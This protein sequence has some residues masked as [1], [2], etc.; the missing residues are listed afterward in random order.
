[1][2]QEIPSIMLIFYFVVPPIGAA[3]NAAVAYVTLRSKALRSPCN[4]LIALLSLADAVQLANITICM[5]F[6]SIAQNNRIRQDLC[7]YLETVPIFG[8]CMS[9]IVLLN[10]AID[11]LLSLMSFY[12]SFI[13]RYSKLYLTAH[14]TS[15]CV[16][17]ISFNV[18]VLFCIKS[19]ENIIVCTLTSAMQGLSYEL[20]I[21]GSLAVSVLVI[22]CYAQFLFFL[23][24]IRMTSC[25]ETNSTTILESVI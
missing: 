22:V 17:A 8:C 21:K 3:G 4:I 25:I 19:E 1:M 9:L 24:Q 10:I 2:P 13:G 20:F 6:Y 5:L 23:G 14:I 18:L 7:S 12:G 15:A 16:F 11:R